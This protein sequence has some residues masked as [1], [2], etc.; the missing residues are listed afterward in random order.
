MPSAWYVIYFLIEIFIIIFV[1][2]NPLFNYILKSKCSISFGILILYHWVNYFINGNIIEHH[3]FTVIHSLFEN[4]IILNLACFLFMKDIKKAFKYISASYLIY[5]LLTFNISFIDPTYNNRLTSAAIHATQFA[6]CAGMAL[7]LFV[8]MKHLLSIPYYAICMLSLPF[9][10]VIIAT[11]TRNGFIFILL[12]SIGLLL[13]DLFHRNQKIS[14]I[15]RITPLAIILIIGGMHII[16]KSSLGERLL[17]TMNKMAIQN[18]SDRTF[19]NVMGDRIP[20]YT[21][22]WRNFTE[23]PIFGIGLW[24]FAPYNKYPYPL[25]SE[26][27]IHLCEGGI[28][29]I[30]LYSIFLFHFTKGVITLW[31]K[32]KNEYTVALLFIWLAY[33]AVG[34]TAREFYYPLFFPPLGL[35]MCAILKRNLVLNLQDRINIYNIIRMNNRHPS[36][37]I[38]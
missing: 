7:L 36:N 18:L 16:N 17:T 4:Y 38:Y 12:F 32:D 3:Y 34:I 22:G 15:I 24:N 1:S 25:H 26:Y 28:I 21:L 2:K 10:F 35:C 14:S 11:G 29:G 30:V 8:Y 33:L 20:F 31:R 23:H 9:I 27:M 37:S 6:Q 5:I 13:S 19:F